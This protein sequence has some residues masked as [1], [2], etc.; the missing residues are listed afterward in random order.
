MTIISK[1]LKMRLS[2]KIFLF[3]VFISSNVYSQLQPVEQYILPIRY[4]DYK[5]CVNSIRVKSLYFKARK[6]V[7]D[8][9]ITE[10][11]AE[12]E[13]GKLKSLLSIDNNTALP[14]Q[15]IKYDTLERITNLKR[16]VYNNKTFHIIQ[17]FSNSSQYPDSTNFYLDDHKNESY[18][19]TFRDTLVIKQEQYTRDTLRS[20]RTF[21]YDNKNRLIGEYRINTKDGF[22]MTLGKSITGTKD[23]KTLYP[24]DTIIYCYY[25]AGDTLIRQKYSN[26]KLDNINKSVTYN[27]QKIDVLEEYRNNYSFNK[28]I[29]KSF[30]DSTIVSRYLINANLDTISSISIFTSDKEILTW[31]EIDNHPR[32]RIIIKT[33]Y[34]SLNNWIKKT[35]INDNVV[36]SEIIREINY[37][38]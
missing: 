38:N 37:C 23:I 2:I 16:K 30:E 11:K 31:S 18:I 15:E 28:K 22:G 3:L 25:K 24:N 8:T 6:N 7:I 5:E 19:N 34:D 33:E 12:F 35:K 9:I 32:L 36:K 27:N 4:L 29:T 17:F 21:K 26:G 20:F 13:N 1:K 10:N 14:S